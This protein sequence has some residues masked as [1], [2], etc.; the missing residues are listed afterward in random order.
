MPQ[1]VKTWPETFPKVRLIGE[2]SFGL[3]MGCHWITTL[4][5]LFRRARH[6]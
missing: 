4:G 5:I 3:H 1:S 2:F 6:Y